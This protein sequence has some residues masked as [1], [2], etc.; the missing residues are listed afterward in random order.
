LHQAIQSELTLK[1]STSVIRDTIMNRF[2][3]KER[4][5]YNHLQEVKELLHQQL[6]AVTAPKIKGGKK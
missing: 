4:A 5:F 2:D 6:H 1:H 3:I